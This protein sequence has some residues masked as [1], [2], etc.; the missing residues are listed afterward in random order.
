MSDPEISLVCSTIGRPGALARLLDSVR[1]CD[2]PERIE[3]VLVDQ[4]T[5]QACARL[6]AEHPTP[7]PYEITTSDPGLSVG[8][9]VGLRLATA[10]VVAFP[11]DNCRYRPDTV[12]R[13]LEA[14]EARAGLA[15]VSGTQITG[16]GEPS[17]LRWLSR[18]AA[19]SRR[20][21]LHTTI[22]STLFLRRPALERVG[23]FD[24]GIG[25][26]APGP[27][28]AGEDS[29]IVL[30]LLAAGESLHYRP[31]IQICQDDDRDAPGPEFVDKM[32]RYGVGQ[33]HL[34]RKHDL[35]ASH[36]LYLSARKLAGSAIRLL[37]GRPVLARADLAFLRGTLDGFRGTAAR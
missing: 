10:P 3:F 28:G 21:F 35:P 30:R 8:R 6:L 36:L 24:E 37:R 33:G 9:N 4:S 31:D 25:A 1:A 12:D 26:G 17:M 23:P 13:A 15:G 2:R 11:D 34:W 29:D 19:V 7:G 14:L 18:S 22:S 32:R 20:N 27:V 16:S 5:D